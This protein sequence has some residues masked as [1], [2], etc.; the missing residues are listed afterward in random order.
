[1]LKKRVVFGLDD[2]RQLIVSHPA[3]VAGQASGRFV[4]M[5]AMAVPDFRRL[6]E[7]RGMTPNRVNFK[8]RSCGNVARVVCASLR[9]RSAFVRAMNRVDKATSF[10]YPSAARNGR[11]GR[12]R[13]NEARNADRS[14]RHTLPFPDRLKESPH[15]D[16]MV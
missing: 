3:I 16:G 12:A 6:H 4:R 8:A 13:S 1:L 14:C 10:A 5:R 7:P 2:Q 15:A 9:A 11:E